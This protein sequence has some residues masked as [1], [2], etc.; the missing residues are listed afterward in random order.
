MAFDPLQVQTLVAVQITMVN[1]TV[2]SILAACR[3]IDPHFPPTCREFTIQ[4]GGAV[5]GTLLIGDA[6]IST[7]RYGF[8]L[9]SS[10]GFGQGRTY[11]CEQG[12]GIPVQ[13]IFLLTATNGML[14]NVE[15]VLF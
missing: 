12:N 4:T 6:L 11:R 1:A 9:Y 15:A 3:A 10:G 8:E 13:D 14:V 7:T 5:P 2:T